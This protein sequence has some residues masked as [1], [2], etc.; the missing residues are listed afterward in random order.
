[1]KSHFDVERRAVNLQRVS[2]IKLKACLAK[3][4]GHCEI[5]E[6]F[7]FTLTILPNGG[8]SANDGIWRN[9]VED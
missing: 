1:M 6:I 9:F 8:I 3:F 2:N 7:V 4:L 5:E